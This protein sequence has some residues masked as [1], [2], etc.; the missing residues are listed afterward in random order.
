MILS[1]KILKVKYSSTYLYI[2]IY[3]FPSDSYIFNGYPTILPKHLQLFKPIFSN[4]YLRWWYILFHFIII[5]VLLIF[6]CKSIELNIE[7]CKRTSL[8]NV[9]CLSKCEL[10]GNSSRVVARRMGHKQLKLHGQR[11]SLPLLC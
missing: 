9:P 10:C 5:L 11:H 8:S 3:I 2:Y 7:Y 4:K 6:I 1:H